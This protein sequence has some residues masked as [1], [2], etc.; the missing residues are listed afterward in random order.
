MIDIKEYQRERHNAKRRKRYRD[1]K[2][3]REFV[4]SRVREYRMR[5]RLEKQR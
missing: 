5:K 2:E 3:W 4:K 1:D